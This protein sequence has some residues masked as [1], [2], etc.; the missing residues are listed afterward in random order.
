[1]FSSTFC[2]KKSHCLIDEYVNFVAEIGIHEN[3]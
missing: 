2:Y 1:M 3:H